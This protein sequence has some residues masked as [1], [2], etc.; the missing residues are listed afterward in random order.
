MRDRI[1]H[2]D[3]ACRTPA[4]HR[5]DRPRSPSGRAG[6]PG[7]PSAAGRVRL[8]RKLR[9]RTHTDRTPARPATATE[10]VGTRGAVPGR[11]GVPACVTSSDILIDLCQSIRLIFSNLPSVEPKSDSANWCRKRW[12]YVIEYHD[13]N[14]VYGEKPPAMMSTV[15]LMDGFVVEPV[16]VAT[17]GCDLLRCG[18]PARTWE[19]GI[20]SSSIARARSLVPN[21]KS[22]HQYAHEQR[23][24]AT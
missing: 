14:D 5:T 22:T 2:A 23:G 12:Y 6:K 10:R 16:R 8:V 18:P 17:V 15:I 21:G 13:M 1:A 19:Q 9:W 11:S 24:D 3:R 7:A 20:S 4:L